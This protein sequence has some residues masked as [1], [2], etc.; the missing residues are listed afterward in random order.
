M[1]LTSFYTA[2][3]GLNNNSYAINVIGD[4]LANM[5]TTAFKSGQATFSELLA[6]VSGVDAGGNPTSTG[7]GSSVNGVAR[8]FTQGTITSTGKSTDVAVNG[9]GYLIVEIEGGQG[10]TRSGSLAIDKEGYLKSADGLQVM[11]YMGVNGVIE[12]SGAIAPIRINQGQLIPASVT[13]EM[14]MTANLDAQAEVDTQFSGSVQIVDT[15][16][17][18]HTVTVTY[19]KTDTGYDWSATIPAV[20]T[21]G[22]ADDEPVE[23]GTGSL[24][25]SENGILTEPE[26]NAMLSISGLSNGAADMDVTFALWDAN[27]SPTITYYANDSAVSNT[28][29]NGFGASAIAS[30]SIDS[31]G[32]ITGTTENGRSIS[33]AQLA[34]ANFP[35]EAGLLKYKGSTFVSFS[36]SGEPSIGTAGSGGRGSFVG[37]ALEQSNVDMASEFVNL[38]QAQRAYQANSRIITT[39]DELY[40]DSINL[41]R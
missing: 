37:S 11:G 16:G 40:Q 20:D 19:T 36:S 27:G 24:V 30:I 3:T 10:Y 25:F 9:K 34:L 22:A 15:L 2:L 4:N 8:N 32:V 29:Q 18:L 38:I 6:G 7:L 23:I 28:T 12:T 5:N 39:S 1:P 41:K 26:E 13:T 35:N 33:L 14:G 31:E 17:T 21:G